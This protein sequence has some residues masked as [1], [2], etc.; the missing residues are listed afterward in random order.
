MNKMFT[1][2]KGLTKKKYAITEQKTCLE[3]YLHKGIDLVIINY[4]TS[5]S[6]NMGKAVSWKQSFLFNIIKVIAPILD[7]VYYWLSRIQS[8]YS[9]NTEL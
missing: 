3:K 9:I 7:Y 6:I 4:I 2:N 1:Q 5:I 8:H